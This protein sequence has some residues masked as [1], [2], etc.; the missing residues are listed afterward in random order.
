MQLILPTPLPIQSLF[1][2]IGLTAGLLLPLL[3]ALVL[4]L[5]LLPQGIRSSARADAICFSVFSL[6]LQ[7]VGVLLMTISGLPALYAVFAMQPLPEMAYLSLLLVFAIGGGV[8]L[9]QDGVLSRIDPVARELPLN[10]FFYTWK[11]TGALIVLFSALTLTLELLSMP[12]GRGH[13]W[14]PHL[15]MLLYGF[16]LSWF[17]LKKPTDTPQGTGF[18]SVARQPVPVPLPQRTPAAAT[19]KPAAQKKPKTVSKKQAKPASRP[20]TQTAS[21]AKSKAKRR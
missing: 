1:D 19:Q 2:A 3:I 10:I 18:S 12:Q 15:I 17:T 4:S 6:L 5:L 14:I 7:S 20:A 16:I 8:Y 11:I 21:R 13:W 9:W